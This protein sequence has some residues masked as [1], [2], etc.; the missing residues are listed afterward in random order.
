MTKDSTETFQ[1][2]ATRGSIEEVEQGV[3]F[4][5]KFNADGLIPCIVTDH[6]T[7]LV[8]MFAYMNASALSMTIRTGEA[9]YWSRSREE[10]WRKGST[11]GHVQHIVDMRIDCDQ[12]SIWL[13][14]EQKGAA[15]HVGYHT[16]FYRSVDKGESSDTKKMTLATT[17]KNKKF[18]P[19]KV[20]G[21]RK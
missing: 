14:V 3:I 1:P 15:C 16:C 20:Y 21:T 11:S 8:L 13:I 12:D 6:Q 18:D 19:S 4:M 10:I 5:P 9:H 7:H 2:F 17:E